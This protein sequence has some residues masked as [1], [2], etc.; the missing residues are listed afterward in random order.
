MFTFKPK[1][2]HKWKL[3][4]KTYAPPYTIQ[5][6]TNIQRAPASSVMDILDKYYLEQHK[7]LRDTTNFLFQCENCTAIKT[8][9]LEGKE[10][11][12]E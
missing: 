5:G 12:D 6:V 10:I 8:E 3:I 1:C 7:A 9:T 11:K 4:S 2:E